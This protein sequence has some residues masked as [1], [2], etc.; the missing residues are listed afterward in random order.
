[1]KMKKAALL[2]RRTAFFILF[3]KWGR[4]KGA[5]LWNGPQ[6]LIALR[7]PFLSYDPFRD[8]DFLTREYIEKQKSAAQI[9]RDCGCA[10][11]TVTARL[12]EFGIELRRDGLPLH[13]RKS[14]LAY[15][16]R[17]Q[18]GRVVPHRG[19]RKVIERFQEMRKAGLSYG[20][21]AHWAN[22]E[23][24]PTKNGVGQWNRRT[25]FEILKRNPEDAPCH[26]PESSPRS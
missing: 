6:A 2:Y 3:N 13:Y 9:A 12:L 5:H 11:S 24:V 26:K 23:G 20:K 4:A 22:H 16:E 10:R 8:K 1:M 14:Q 19:E 21:L 25:I 7:E 17:I 15:G 18:S